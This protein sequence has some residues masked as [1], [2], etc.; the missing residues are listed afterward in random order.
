MTRSATLRRIT[1]PASFAVV[2]L[3]LV[4]VLVLAGFAAT[5]GTPTTPDLAGRTF[6]STE[7]AGHELVPG[8]SVRI[9]FEEGHLSA[10]AAC[11][12]VFGSAQ[13]SDGVLEAGPLASTMMACSPELMAQDAWLAELLEAG[14]TIALDGS[15]LTI[16][17]ETST[18]VL[19]EVG[20]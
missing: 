12:T 7:V 8:T 20:R 2:G 4:A 1:R 15:T 19:A 6:A 10:T 9:T 5:G 11:N 3:G 17:G 14:P 16:S 13:W 18:L